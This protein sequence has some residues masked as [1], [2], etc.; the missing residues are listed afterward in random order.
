MYRLAAELLR[1]FS[2]LFLCSLA[3]LVFL[4]WKKPARRG[5]KIVVLVFCCLLWLTS[6]ESVGYL[7]M[8]SL[9]SAYPPW[10]GVPERADT[11]VLL[12]A[13]QSVYDAS[14]SRVDLDSSAMGRCLEAARL[15][16]K[17][18]GCRIVAS[19]GKVF[20]DTPG[21]SLAQAMSD[22]LVDLGVRPADIV[23]EDQSRTT[24]ENALYTE[25]ILTRLGVH[26]VIL[27][28]DATHMRRA[29]RCL[30]ALGVEVTPAP[31]NYRATWFPWTVGRFLPTPDG[32][33]DVDAA[34]HEWVGIVWYRLRGW[35]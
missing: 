11:I 13:G 1:P 2:L 7:A 5:V 20:A 15:Y 12:S 10:E 25:E 4:W 24:H 6:V 27:V 17:A 26:R 14:G 22:F 29:A 9:E 30:R 34:L 3:G 35:I 21:P 8:L 31:C 32:A 23:L 16:K 18:G 28:T 33:K 19:G